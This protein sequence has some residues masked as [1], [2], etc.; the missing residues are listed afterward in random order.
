MV[1]HNTQE[2]HLYVDRKKI[3]LS[4]LEVVDSFKTELM[5]SSNVLGLIVFRYNIMF[6]NILNLL[7]LLIIT[8]LFL[9]VVDPSSHGCYN[10]VLFKWWV[11]TQSCVV[12]AFC[13]VAIYFQN[14][15]KVIYTILICLILNFLISHEAKKGVLYKT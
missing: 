10:A 1:H 12:K 7:L 8:G 13:R 3:N 15:K 6:N 5:G 11:A 4:F 9:V 2:I 14:I